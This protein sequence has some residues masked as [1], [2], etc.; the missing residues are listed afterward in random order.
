[1]PPEDDGLHIELGKRGM[2]EWWYFDAHFEGGYTIVAFFYAANPNP[3]NAGKAGVELTLLRPDGQKTQKFIRYSLNDFRASKEKADVKIGHNT[4]TSDYSTSSL[5]VYKIHL[6]EAGLAFDLIYSVSVHGWKPGSGFSHFADRGYFAW[7][8]PI[9]RADVSGTIRDGDKTLS[10]S[11][12]GYHDHNWLNF[13]FQML[14][15]Y[16]MWGRV[17]SKNFT[18]SY[19]YIRCKPKVDNHVVKVLMLA[20]KENVIL[21]TGEY[22]LKKEDFE[23][24]TPADHQYPKSLTFTIPDKLE[25]ELKVQRVLEAENMLNNFSPVLRFLAKYLLRM[26]PGYFRLLS[27][28]K[29]KV[30]HEGTSSTETGTTLHEIVAFKEIV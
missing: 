3:G 8:V 26:K 12:V 18:V 30:T 5:P 24:S 27:D 21:S 11:G 4:L 7:V 2:Y 10:V 22:E 6:E 15:E 16:W 19:A 13:P 14:I 9:P 28:F 17:Y 1:M 20:Q 25:M 23:F 29:V